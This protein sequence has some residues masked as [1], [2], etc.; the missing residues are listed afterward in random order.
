[1]IAQKNVTNFFYTTT[2]LATAALP[3]VTATLGVRRIGESLCDATAIVAHDEFQVIGYNSNGA[4]VESPMYS[5][6]NLIS[7]NKI[8]MSALVSQV[9]HIGYNGTDGDIVATNLGNYLVTIGLR[10]MLKQIGGKRLYKFAEYQA[11]TTAKNYDI[12]IALAGSLATNMSK[13]AFVR[14]IAAAISSSAVVTAYK[15]DNSAT[16]VQGSKYITMGTNSQYNTGTELAVGDYIRLNVAGSAPTVA[17]PVYRVVELTSTTVFKVDRPVTNASGT[18]ANATSDTSVIPKA[19][20]EGATIKWGISLTGNDAAAP[21]VPGM[22]GPNNIQFSVG[23]SSDF[24]TTNV[25]LTTTPF[26]GI[27]TYKLLAQIDWELQRNNTEAYR[28]AEHLVTLAANVSS[29]DTITNVYVLNFKNNNTV[30]VLGGASDSY[31][32]LMIAC[33]TTSDSDLATVFTL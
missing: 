25:R 33:D 17:S 2:A 6:D 28:I 30:S 4:I 8:A 31:V 20:A 27:A 21:F 19:T 14:V 13:D 26:I 29:T 22:F 1:M 9:S 16:V 12:A 10:D 5:W 11:G 23:V 32:T 24:S 3:T 15:M 7:K 18:Y